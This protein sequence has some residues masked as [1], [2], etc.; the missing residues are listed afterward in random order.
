MSSTSI[1]MSAIMMISDS[2]TVVLA[3]ITLMNGMN[4]VVLIVVVLTVGIDVVAVWFIFGGTTGVV[5]S[6][7]LKF[8]AMVCSMGK[9][10]MLSR[11]T[12]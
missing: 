5:H 8:R 6:D 12:K 11:V 1:I 3:V 2:L 10:D 4:I 7:E 9:Y